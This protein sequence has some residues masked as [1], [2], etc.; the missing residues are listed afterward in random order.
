VGGNLLK[1]QTPPQ[2]LRCLTLGRYTASVVDGELRICGPQPLAGPLP[3]SIK[4][5]RD[6]LIEF[7]NEW[8][9]GVWPP[10]SGSALR[11][12]ERILGGGLVA[13]LDA[14]EAALDEA[15]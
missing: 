8:A 3:A 4:A 13:A 1:P 6:E 12:A 9:D 14:I 15:A 5:R 10:A 11:E 2:I 7:L